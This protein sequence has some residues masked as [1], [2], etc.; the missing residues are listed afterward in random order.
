MSTESVQRSEEYAKEAAEQFGVNVVDTEHLL[1][2]LLRERDEIT[3]SI[4]R[5]FQRTPD[6]VQVIVERL[7][8]PGSGRKGQDLPLSP[9]S[10]RALRLAYDEAWRL[11]SGMMG[12]EHL[13]IGL[14]LEKEGKAG[15]ILVSLGIR[16]EQ[17]MD[18][19]REPN[20]LLRTAEAPDAPSETLLR[21]AQGP[22]ETDEQ[23]LLRPAGM[24]N[25]DGTR[26]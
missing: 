23:M 10:D 7:T 11:K 24:E 18:I 9:Q 26:E 21:P 5:R 8:M 25:E 4:L 13:L 22:G 3:V 1:L 15:R 19:V 17:V 14:L 20:L 2:G 6:E 16:L 12:T